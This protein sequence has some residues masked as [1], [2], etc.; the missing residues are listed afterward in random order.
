MASDAS[1]RQRERM[2]RKGLLNAIISIAKLLAAD[3][4]TVLYQLQVL[5]GQPQ[6]LVRLA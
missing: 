5:F 3:S 4:A 2:A 1:A 6:L